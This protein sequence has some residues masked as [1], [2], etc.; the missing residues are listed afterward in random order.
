MSCVTQTASAELCHEDSDIRLHQSGTECGL[1][2]PE[3]RVPTYGLMRGV[4]AVPVTSQRASTMPGYGG[5]SD[6]GESGHGA[7]P[8]C[9]GRA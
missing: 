7:E 4:T 6:G 5:E 8:R 3:R 1:S 2:Y 9:K